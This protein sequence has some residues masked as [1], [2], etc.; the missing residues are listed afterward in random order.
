MYTISKIFF[1]SWQKKILENNYFFPFNQYKFIL[2]QGVQILLW[3]T[4]GKSFIW[5]NI[6]LSFIEISSQR[7]E[8]LRN[9][10]TNFCE[11]GA[12][13]AQNLRARLC[14]Q[15]FWD[16]IFHNFE[17]RY[18]PISP[19]IWLVEFGPQNEIVS[20]KCGGHSKKAEI[21]APQL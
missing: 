12:T 11:D 19:Q 10:Y 2:L 20:G 21:E 5:G 4:V 6:I 16:H 14:I 13:A 3:F 18:V 15:N 17:G 7:E 9:E 1:F 8:R